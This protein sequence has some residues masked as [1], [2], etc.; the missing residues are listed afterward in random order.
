MFT[1]L[2]AGSN[3]TIVPET[4]TLSGSIRFLYPGGD[5]IRDRFERII[6]HTCKAHRAD[7]ELTFEVGNDLLFNNETITRLAR[8]SAAAVLG[9]SHAVTAMVKTMAGE[10]FAAFSD[11]VPAAFAFVGAR[12]PDGEI[13]YPHH[14]PRFTFD[15]KALL[16]GA[17]LYVRVAKQFLEAET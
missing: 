16:I 10:D 7:Y 13:P 15:E 4:V 1:A 8:E 14:H 9:D 11:A 12:D 2:R 17:E 6:E 5:E 3:S